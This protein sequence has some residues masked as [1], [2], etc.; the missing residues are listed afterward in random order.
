MA[1]AT[2]N[3]TAF[4]PAAP[5]AASAFAHLLAT[6]L[7]APAPRVQRVPRPRLFD[8]LDAAGGQALTLVS[9][10]AGFGK[11]T[12]V[13]D[14]L[15]TRGSL[16]PAGKPAGWLSLDAG[17]ND[18]RRFLTYFGAACER[19]APGIAASLAAPL[20]T[21]RLPGPEELLVPFLNELWA[22]AATGGGVL[23]LDDYHVIENAEV[24][25]ALAFCLDNLPPSFQLVI[26]TRSDPPLPLARLRARGQLCELRAE[27]LQF[28][29]AEAASFLRE[30]MGLAVSGEEVVALEE[31][32]EGWIAGLQ[33]AAL[34]LRQ[35]LRQRAD[36]R[37]FLAGFTGSHRFVLDYLTQEVLDRQPPERLDFLLRT[38]VLHRLCGPLCEALTGKPGGQESLETLDAAN[39]FL[40]P[41]DER[42]GWYRYHHL[43][44][45]LLQEQLRRQLSGPEIAEL[46]RRAADWLAERDLADEALAHATAAADWGRVAKILERHAPIALNR[47]DVGTL[48]RWLTALPEACYVSHPQLLLPRGAVL[49]A[50]LYFEEFGAVLGQLAGAAAATRDPL[51]IAGADALQAVAFTAQAE[52]GAVID[53]AS[54]SLELLPDAEGWLRSLVALLLGMALVRTGEKERAATA[55][56]VAAVEGAAAGNYMVLVGAR[57]NLGAIESLSG[58]LRRAYDIHRQTVAGFAAFGDNPPPAAAQAYDGLAEIYTEWGEL[59][60]ALACSTTANRLCRAGAVG[61]H[62]ARCLGTL[63]R[64]HLA[65]REFAA[66]REVVGEIDQLLRRS[67]M[68]RF[69]AV[70][71]AMRGRVDVLQARD[72]G[73]PELLLEAERWAR[74]QGLFAPEELRNRL[75][76]D[77]PLDFCHQTAVRLLLGLGRWEE[78]LALLLALRGW[79]EEGGWDRSRIEVDLLEALAHQG[80]AE[81]AGDSPWEAFEPLARAIDRAEPEGFLQLFLEEGEPAARLLAAYERAYPRALARPFGQKLLQAF[82]LE[83]SLPRPG[84][85]PA[86][87][88]GVEAVS[89]RELEVLRVIAAG[90]SNS[91]AARKLFLSPFTIKKHLENIYGKLGVRNRTEAIARAQA[92]GLLA[93]GTAG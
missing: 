31:R 73:R 44:G 68:P 61:G 67:P 36:A 91:E 12:V 25:A 78:A 13:S 27:D 20:S 28:T 47:G 33:M 48:L 84:G 11:S 63:M 50:S 76:C 74:E 83:T 80:A 52:H 8:R 65:R 64:L 79:A 86:S 81:E 32:T 4:R 22:A 87:P 18:L 23:V 66:A 57:F 35:P 41:L 93:P 62:S 45:G 5:P 26:A 77:L 55:L 60:E 40:I 21:P 7:H 34:V 88:A 17:D 54:R 38:S 37:S 46:H 6:K 49:F 56:E 69:Q 10:P 3:V 72:E 90:L 71:D 30:T 16:A 19:C 82:R 58:R 59:E 85:R 9:A 39:L 43:F 42:R 53:S 15:A 75:M 89:E 24:H 14:W 70:L 51:L 29:A 2:S 92:Q 1:I